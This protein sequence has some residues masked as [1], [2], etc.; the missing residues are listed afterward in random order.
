[1]TTDQQ[2]TESM[3]ILKARL[4]EQRLVA[5]VLAHDYPMATVQRANNQRPGELR[6][7][8]ALTTAIYKLPWYSQLHRIHKELML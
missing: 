2:Y 8:M 1:M 7:L 5:E 6:L 4:A 3:A